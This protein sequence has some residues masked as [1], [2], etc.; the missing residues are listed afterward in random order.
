MARKEQRT[1]GQF[2]EWFKR[3][4]WRAELTQA[5]F[6]RRGEFTPGQVSFWARGER[7]PEPASIQRLAAVLGMDVD[8][9]LSHAGHRPPGYDE[10]D[11]AIR[12]VIGIMHRLP[13]SDR[14]EVELCARFRLERYQRQLRLGEQG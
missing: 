12:A 11:E 10:P 14:A 3:A 4:L 1:R 9:V 13:D 8:E 7:L 5:E 6:A 2:G